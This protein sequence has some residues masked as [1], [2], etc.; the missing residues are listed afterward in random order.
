MNTEEKSL[1][2]QSSSFVVHDSTTTKKSRCIVC[3]KSTWLPMTCSKCQQEFC[4]SHQL[5]ESHKCPKIDLYKKDIV[6]LVAN[7]PSNLEYI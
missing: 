5:P 4:I 3:R 7:K 6:D 2:T 1:S